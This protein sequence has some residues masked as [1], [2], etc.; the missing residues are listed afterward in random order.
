M[1]QFIEHQ[2]QRGRS[3]V[4]CF[5]VR[6][7]IDDAERHNGGFIDEAERRGRGEGSSHQRVAQDPGTVVDESGTGGWDRRGLWPPSQRGVGFGHRIA[8]E[9]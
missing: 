8:E 4:Y 7:F 2:E 6:G 9:G 1:E 5:K 3:M